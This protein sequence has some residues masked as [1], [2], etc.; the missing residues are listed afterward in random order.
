M[1]FNW[2]SEY[3]NFLMNYNRF[4]NTSHA[5]FTR[6]LETLHDMHYDNRFGYTTP[7]RSTN[8]DTF[9]SNVETR[10]LR[11]RQY[12]RTNHLNNPSTTTY[13]YSTFTFNRPFTSSTTSSLRPRPP[14][15][16]HTRNNTNRENPINNEENNDEITDDEETDEETDM[17][18]NTQ[19]NNATQT[20][21]QPQTS[22]RNMGRDLL[23]NFV[24]IQDLGL[25]NTGNETNDTVLNMVNRLFQQTNNGNFAGYSVSIGFTD[26]SN[27]MMDDDID[28]TPPIPTEEQIERLTTRLRYN[29][30]AHRQ[31][32]CPIGLQNFEDNDEIIQINHCNHI[33]NPENLLRW[34]T[35]SSL[36]P[37]CRH[38][39]LDNA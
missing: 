12:L 31:R 30:N 32:L 6:I 36:C 35:A 13:P 25:N 10:P 27:N 17:N 37:V 7:I 26:I 28:I 33:F 34:F 24:N 23:R 2:N 3:S 19:T 9:T 22:L 4:I 5:N 20:Q 14:Q 29:E 21:M 8:Q 15:R 18:E 39:I 16:N 38:N 1:D 11:F